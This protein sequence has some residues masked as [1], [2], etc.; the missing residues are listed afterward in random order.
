MSVALELGGVEKDR[1]QGPTASLSEC[2]YKIQVESE[3]PQSQPIESA[4]GDSCPL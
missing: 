4:T 1:F 3:L 2:I